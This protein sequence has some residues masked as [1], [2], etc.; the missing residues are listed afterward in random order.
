MAYTAACA[1]VSFP[2]FAATTPI[3]MALDVS[4]VDF[5]AGKPSTLP[6]TSE[7]T[8]SKTFVNKVA[9]SPIADCGDIDPRTPHM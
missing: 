3:L 8:S 2:K 5:R 9:V 4:I 1:Y 6:A 7:N